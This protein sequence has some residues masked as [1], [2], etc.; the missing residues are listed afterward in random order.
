MISLTLRMAAGE[1]N[2]REREA[3]YFQTSMISSQGKPLVPRDTS[4][5]L[6]VSCNSKA[7]VVNMQ[8]G[9]VQEEFTMFTA[10]SVIAEVIWV[11]VVSSAPVKVLCF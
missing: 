1:P 9:W 8:G 2:E 10:A 11:S 3:A 5:R 4:C 6:E 7:I